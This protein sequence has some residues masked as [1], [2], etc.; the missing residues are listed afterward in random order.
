M[1]LSFKFQLSAAPTGHVILALKYLGKCKIHPRQP[2]MPRDTVD[3]QL[4]C[5]FKF[6]ARRG[7][8]VN[9]TSCPLYHW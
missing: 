2:Q 7:W 9:T 1:W 6:G 8:V 5:L 4:H 3:V